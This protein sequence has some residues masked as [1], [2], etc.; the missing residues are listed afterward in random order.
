MNNL[1][2]RISE[3]ALRDETLRKCRILLGFWA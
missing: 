2:E 1:S 3:P